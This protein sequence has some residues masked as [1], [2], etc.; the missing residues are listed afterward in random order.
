MKVSLVKCNQY[1]LQKLEESLEQT[2]ALLGGVEKYIQKGTTV[3]LKPN[4]L[5]RSAPE[6]AT[7]T[8]PIFVAAL[9]KILVQAGAI[10]TIADS[11]GG[12]YSPRVLKSLYTACGYDQIPA[13]SGAILNED[14]GFT[15]VQYKKDQQIYPFTVI[16]P[17]LENDIVISAAKL[18]THGFTTYTGAVKN[19]FG[20]VPGTYKAEYHMRF[21]DP[22]VFCQVLVDL[23]EM[24]KPTLSFIDG[25]VGMEGAGPSGGTPREVGVI[26]AGAN[27]HAVDLV[28][29]KIIGLTAQQ[30]PT[31]KAAVTQKLCPE[32]PEEVEIVGEKLETFLMKDYKQAIAGMGSYL[33]NPLLKK[34]LN[35]FAPRPVF[36]KE[37]C[38]R[39]GDCK[40]YCPADAIEITDYPRLDKEK[41]I[42]CFCCQELCPKKAV[43]IKRI[44]W[45]LR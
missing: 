40:K 27:P 25:I 7:A 15:T 21:P 36:L 39:C 19:L 24:A 43:K 45:I 13:L 20:L 16:N 11:P 37:I 1:E 29:A 12:T 8:H 33:N 26:L 28:G 4:L 9:A 35:R 23:C 2:F 30:V 17:L 32:K 14:A 5:M 22:D 10:V 6:N 41:C 3:L 34:L 42:R 18:K 31:L 38:V 44:K